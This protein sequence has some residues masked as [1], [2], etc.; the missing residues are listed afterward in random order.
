MRHVKLFEDFIKEEDPLAALTGGGEEK[1][2]EDPLEK[3]KKEQMAK[4]K[5][6]AKKHEK[7][8]DKK[9]D[10]VDDLLKDMPDV[11]EKLGDKIQDA[12]KQQDRVKIHNA[13]LDVTY[14]QQDFQD[15]GMEDKIAKLA[16]LKKVLDTLDKSFTSD[17]RM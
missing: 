8:V 10:T 13:I 16:R 1:P 4:D 7:M 3:K 9:E 11:R 15:Q 17:K 14:M 6:A 12:I 5:A 2:K